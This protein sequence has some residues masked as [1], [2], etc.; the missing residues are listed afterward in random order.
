MKFVV[1]VLAFLV[2]VFLS[3][4]PSYGQIPRTLSYQGVLADSLGNPKPDGV[5]VF[6]FSLFVDSTGGNPLWSEQ[7][8]VALKRGLFSVVLGSG[9][10]F[11]D[12]V[13]FDRQYWLAIACDR[14]GDMFPRLPLTAVGYSI[15]AVH[16]DTAGYARSSPPSAFADSTRIAGNVAEGAITNTEIS[17]T[18]KISP[19]K[20]LGTAWTSANDGAGSGLDADLLDGKHASDFQSQ[21]EDYGRQGVAENLYEGTSTLTSKYINAAGPDTMSSGIP[22]PVLFLS[23]TAS[24]TSSTSGIEGTA[25][26]GASGDAYGGYFSTAPLGDG[27]HYGAM[28]IGTGNSYSTVYGVS[29]LGDNASTGD[30][31]GGYFETATR[32][33]GFHYGVKV[34]VEGATSSDVYGT[35][36]ESYS[37][38]TGT[39]YGSYASATNHTS[40]DAI[41]GYFYTYDPGT[42]SHY[43]IEAHCDG[44]SDG[45]AYGAS[46]S[47]ENAS[48]GSAYGGFFYTSTDGTGSHYGITAKGYGFASAPT[49]GS[50]GWADNP[51]SGNLYGG[52]FTTDTAG[53]GVHYGVY[54]EETAGKG[55]AVYA[56]GDFAGSGAKYAV[57]KT[58]RGHRLMSVIESPE[59]WF[60][61]F[62][63]GNLT[64]GTAHVKL[65]LLFLE[66]V[67]IDQSHPMKVYI[68]ITSGNPMNVVVSKGTTGFDVV[69]SE[70]N[71]NATFDYR[72]VA[73]RKGYENER[74]MPTS[75]GKDD[76]NLYPELRSESHLRQQSETATIERSTKR[77]EEH[78]AKIRSK[79]R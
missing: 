63:E 71:S 24:S 53:S 45:G 5:H 7:K 6:T 32:G 33:S 46:A 44:H 65:D 34:R 21:V 2:V 25:S 22:G 3:A 26:N 78:R 17:D 4:A 42:G 66:T 39:S 14:C 79:S 12:S 62:G 11:P 54:G 70:S 60:E 40:G 77:L 37:T 64:N 41:G 35:A 30:A 67:T 47:A 16:A 43:G 31:I 23:N 27:E 50:Y 61:D 56:A 51:S 18:A 68:Q 69:A 1:E 75:L 72:I 73:K 28:A 15:R 55:A 13:R 49:Y 29:G 74:M 9:T 10:A 76:P 19:A 36:C 38:G 20:I 57:A 48:G 58:S 8:T 59:I 52:Y